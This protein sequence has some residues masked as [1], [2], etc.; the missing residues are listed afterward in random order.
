MGALFDEYVG[1][2]YELSDTAV[3]AQEAI[4]EIEEQTE[5]IKNEGK[6]EYNG[7]IN[8]IAEGLQDSA[9]KNIDALSNVNDSITD[10][11]NAIVASIQE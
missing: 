4:E 11:N 6:E 7:L 8:R 9:Q 3:E 5:D 1:E 10:M 2:L